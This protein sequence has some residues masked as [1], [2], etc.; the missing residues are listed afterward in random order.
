[1]RL[2]S[3][4]SW[5]LAIPSSNP[6][7]HRDPPVESPIRSGLVRPPA[8][9]S[10]GWRHP[11]AIAEVMI[12][13]QKRIN[14]A[15][16]Q[17]ASELGLQARPAAFLSSRQIDG[18]CQGHFVKVRNPLHCWTL[19]RG[20]RCVATGTSR[21][22]RWFTQL[23]RTTH[24]VPRQISQLRPVQAK[25]VC[26]RRGAGCASCWDPSVADQR[27]AWAVENVVLTAP[28]HAQQPCAFSL[29]I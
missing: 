3:Q 8:T 15:W 6:T 12:K 23:H 21:G 2:G 7:R 28:D 22:P 5:G 16:Q 13:A 10:V 9:P 14:K 29:M 1:M 18:I 24:S 27:C 4:V 26:G 17:A 19:R 20:G 11:R 25:P